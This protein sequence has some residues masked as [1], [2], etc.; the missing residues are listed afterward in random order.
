M[1]LFVIRHAKAHER[2][3]REWDDDSQ[4]PLTRGGARRFAALAA[5]IAK[6]YDAPEAV[7]A[8]GYVRAW[9]TAEIL[10]REAKWPAPV[11]ANWLECSSDASMAEVR[12]LLSERTEQSLAIVGHEPMLSELVSE[13]TGCHGPGVVMNKGAVAVLSIRDPQSIVE[14]DHF[15]G[16]SAELLALVDPKWVSSGD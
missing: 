14:T 10:E 11:R 9:E 16:S 13:L 3:T 4:R 2:D 12:R 15:L 1:L 7:L 8:S 6:R 5:V